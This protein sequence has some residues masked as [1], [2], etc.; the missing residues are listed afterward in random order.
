M[1]QGEED[2]DDAQKVDEIL[3]EIRKTPQIFLLSSDE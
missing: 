3:S 2:L 1:D